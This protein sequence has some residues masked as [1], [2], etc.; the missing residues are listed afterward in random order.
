MYSVVCDL[1]QFAVVKSSPELVSYWYL[2]QDE[3]KLHRK[4]PA[5]AEISSSMAQNMSGRCQNYRRHGR[6]ARTKQFTLV[7]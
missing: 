7:I 1:R 4:R 5:K 3:K 6:A 2:Y